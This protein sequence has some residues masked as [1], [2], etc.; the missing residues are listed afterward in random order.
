MHT[1]DWLAEAF[2]FRNMREL[3]K[4]LGHHFMYA[5]DVGGRSDNINVLELWPILAGVR[6]WGE[7]WTDQTVV[8]V[9]DKMQV[10]AA[11]NSG[12]SK[13]KITMAWLLLI[14]WS[15]ISFNFEIQSVYI[16]T[17]TNV[18]CDSLSR[19]DKVKNI[20]RI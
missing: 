1:N 19:L 6:R 5:E 17:K 8:F 10:I 11:L 2:D 14:F 9:T 18:I 12:R 15:S 4:W 16:N 13:N 7:R 3:Q 20:A